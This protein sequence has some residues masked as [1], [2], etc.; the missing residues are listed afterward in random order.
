MN[1]NKIGE[2]IE[3]I[4]KERYHLEE[5]EYGF[6]ARFIDLPVEIKGCK[7]VHQ[8]GV[9]RNGIDAT[10]AGRFWIDNTAHNLLLQLG[11]LYIFVVYET[12]Y[13]NELELSVKCM[14]AHKLNKLII[15][16]D[17]TKIR[18]D[19]LFPELKED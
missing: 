11:G 7:K 5:S 2:T 4:I 16:G 17:N 6:D 12:I 19:L 3:G 18:Y 10:T 1:S 8:N 9:R 15:G 13:L 14:T